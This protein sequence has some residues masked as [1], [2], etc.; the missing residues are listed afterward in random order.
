MKSRIMMETT[1]HRSQRAEWVSL[2]Y[3]LFFVLAVLSPS[4]YR[5]SLFGIDETT[6]EEMT[7]FLF[8]IAGLIT[9]TLYERY[10]DRREKEREIVEHDYNRLKF[11]LMESYAYIGSVNRKIELLK[12]MAEETSLTLVDKKR[13]PKDLLFSIAANACAAAGAQGSLL[14]IVHLDKLRTERE[15]FHDPE[16]TCQFRIS[17]RELRS[18]HDTQVPKSSIPQEDGRHLFVVPSDR[19]ATNDCKAYLLLIVDEKHREDVDTSL[20]KIFV[21]Q[22][23]MLYHNFLDGSAALAESAV[24]SVR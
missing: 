15:F 9:F 8:G 10:M 2:L 7:I 13:F 22:A 3:L 12:K 17:N 19:M 24:S 23:E 16:H 18:M 11:E 4:I 20:L 1:K 6:L 14:R 21:N 5:R